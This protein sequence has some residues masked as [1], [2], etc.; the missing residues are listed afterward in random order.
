[1]AQTQ[2]VTSG[3]STLNAI[4]PSAVE[5]G[6]IAGRNMA[7]EKIEYDGSMAMNSI[8]FFGL[9]VISMGITRP[10]TKDYEE[11]SAH[12]EKKGIYKKVVLKNGIIRGFIAVG[13]IENSGVYNALIKHEIDVTQ[14]KDILL[15]E[16]FDY[17][18]AMPLI[19]ENK[20]KFDKDEFMDSIITY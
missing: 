3:E 8:E 10:K 15:D 16:K 13:D 9:P 19:K 1:M 17:A 4:W 20:A 5:Q 12:N 6:K 14:I 18:K 11:L 2:D 7:G